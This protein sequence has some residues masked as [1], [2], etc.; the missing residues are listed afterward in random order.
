MSIALDGSFG[1]QTGI[2]KVS[3]L[4]LGTFMSIC[5][6]KVNNALQTYV[7]WLYFRPGG[8]LFTLKWCDFRSLQ[9][10]A[11]SAQLWA[12][13]LWWSTSGLPWRGGPVHILATEFNFTEKLAGIPG[14]GGSKA[15]GLMAGNGWTIFGGPVKGSTGVHCG[16]LLSGYLAGFP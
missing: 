12:G 1:G 4:G 9:V 2:G 11:S 5:K 14:G 3:S 13:L 8:V 6:I 15:C 16:W 7:F 10:T